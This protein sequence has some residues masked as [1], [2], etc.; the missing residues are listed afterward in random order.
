M[1]RAAMVRRIIALEAGPATLKTMAGWAAMYGWPQVYEWQDLE[2]RRIRA[3]LLPLP[4]DEP[5]P[6]ETPLER[7]FHDAMEAAYPPDPDAIKV[8]R[9]KL[10]L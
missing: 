1:S 2:G 5:I 7:Q 3:K 6:E 4:G 8:L 9:E 10:G